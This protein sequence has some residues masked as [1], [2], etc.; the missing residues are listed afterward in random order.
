MS[1]HGEENTA[2]SSDR[3]IVRR[4]N[5][6][7][8]TVAVELD[9]HC[10]SVATVAHG[11]RSL[12]DGYALWHS[13]F[14]LCCHDATRVL[15]IDGQRHCRLGQG[16]DIWQIDDILRLQSGWGCQKEDIEE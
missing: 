7:A 10:M 6:H 8:I 15:Q 5:H 14:K 1:F 3:P 11:A 12:V 13:Q 2:V 4:E 9:V 16:T